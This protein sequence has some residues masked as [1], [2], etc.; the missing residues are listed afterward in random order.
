ML[1]KWKKRPTALFPLSNSKIC[2]PVNHLQYLVHNTLKTGDTLA[3]HLVMYVHHM[4]STE[5][6]FSNI[7]V[8]KCCFGLLGNIKIVSLWHIK[9]S[10]PLLFSANTDNKS[11]ILGMEYWSMCKQS[12][13]QSLYFPFKCYRN[14]ENQQK[15]V[16]YLM[17]HSLHC[18][19]SFFVVRNLKAIFE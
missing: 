8:T 3:I 14:L 6:I 5:I 19:V 4:G 2:D 15:A 17:L 12:L 16:Y 1:R 13:F 7:S 18:H 10:K 11:W 9:L